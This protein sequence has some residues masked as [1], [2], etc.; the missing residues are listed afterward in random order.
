LR[1]VSAFRSIC[2]RSK[3]AWLATWASLAAIRLPCWVSLLC[4]CAFGFA[5]GRRAR[6]DGQFEVG[7]FQAHQQVALVD[8]LVVLDQHLSMRAPAGWRR[9]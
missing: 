2:E 1:K 9:G 4:A 7:G 5:G 6:R 3:V 8:V